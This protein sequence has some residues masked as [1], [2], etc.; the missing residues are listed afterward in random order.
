MLHATMLTTP[1]AL[2]STIPVERVI[3]AVLLQEDQMNYKEV[4][5]DQV[6]IQ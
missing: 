5:E 1:G 2:K 4:K 6:I 3:G